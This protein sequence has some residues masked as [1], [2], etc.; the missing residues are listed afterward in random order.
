MWNK[1]TYYTQSFLLH[2]TVLANIIC[3]GLPVSD[4]EIPLVPKSNKV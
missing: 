2:N 3:M 1:T 4:K